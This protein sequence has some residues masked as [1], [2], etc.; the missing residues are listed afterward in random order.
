MNKF[1]NIMITGTITSAKEDSLKIYETLV[2]E[3]SQYTDKIYSPIDTINFK[4]TNEEM[5]TRV[6]KLLQ[7]T[8]LVIAEMSSPSTGQGMELQ[9]ATIL[10]IPILVIAKKDSK[11][12]G[13][14][15]GCKCLKDIVYYEKI[16][17]IKDN[18]IRFIEG[19]E[20]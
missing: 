11:I 1:K 6:M 18:I 10:N 15:K 2:E 16:E 9:E 17:D 5:Y 12:S 20:Q 8:N 4:G 19:D 13:L 14:V 3:L 7:E